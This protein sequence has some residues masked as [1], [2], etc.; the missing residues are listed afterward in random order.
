MLSPKPATRLAVAIGT[1]IVAIATLVFVRGHW[2]SIYDDTLIYLRYVR[3]LHAGCGP[4]FNCGQPPVEGFTSPLYLAVLWAA[5]AITDQPIWWTQLICTACVIAAGGL[6]I[7]TAA[8]LARDDERRW[9]APVA[10]LSTAVVLALDPY[11]LLNANIGMETALAATSIAFVALAAALRRPWLLVA[12]AILA[13][14]VRP[15]G[16]LCV[17][18]LPLL[19]ALRKPRYLAAAA[20]AVI[21]ITVARSAIFGDLLPNTYYAKSGGTWRHAVL[22][23]RYIADCALDFPL[24]LVAVLAWR[25]RY[26]PA[27]ALAWLVFF[28]RTGGD[29]FEYSRLWVPLV[30]ALSALALVQ[31]ARL[32]LW[33]APV[34][35]LVVG[36]RAAVA[37]HIPPQGT[38]ARVVEWMMAGTYIR[39]HF[40][41]NTL[42]ATV[43]I[44]AIGYYSGEP[45]LDLVGLAD[46]TIAHSAHTVPAELLT[47]QWIGHERHDTVYVLSRAP[48]LIVTTMQR[49]TP[50]TLAD[51]KAGFWADWLLLQA[52]KMGSAPYHVRDAE[53]RPGDHLLM[54][55]RDAGH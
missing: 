38:S 52:I 37:H 12:A 7:A 25:T 4:T 48:A 6:A 13:V 20:G 22:G 16:M 17:V 46:R 35:A 5:T 55:E 19:P 40:P 44:G 54:F 36:V 3:N 15:E 18:A 27:I 30:P 23:A 50:W 9:L 29:T 1:A 42:V 45:I 51:A 41:P 21:A 24:C 10:A 14:L 32:A 43:P 26:V 47:K 31:L 28:L 11:F 8:V 34:V 33:A 2:D 53:L 49:A 39:Q